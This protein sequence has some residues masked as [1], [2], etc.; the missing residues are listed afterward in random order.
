MKRINILIATVI[1][2]AA[3]N[4]PAQKKED[5]STMQHKASGN[6][7]IMMQAMDESMLAMH[8]IKQTGNADYDFAAMMIPHHEGAI[9][10]AKAAQEKGKSTT[11]IS[12][13]EKVIS[14]QKK[15][16]ESLNNFLKT[17]DKTPSANAKE[18]KLALDG[19]MK[20]MMDGMAETK[21]TGNI[22]HDFV[23]L[24]IPH[25]QSAV[26]MA[27]AYLPHAQHPQIKKMANEI[28]QAQ[29]AEIK[30][31]KEQN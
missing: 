10:M 16:I 27:K 19:S 29:E 15:E 22:D 20:P 5:H 26:D 12:F 2:F 24:M 18:I 28:I 4:E 25:H 11:L 23:A 13:A 3:C 1:L 17:A 9:V 7:N 6:K 21:L 31:L 8:Q 14:A 30:W